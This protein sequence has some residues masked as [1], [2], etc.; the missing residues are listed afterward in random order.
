MN[1]IAK[2]G[3]KR[4]YDVIVQEFPEDCVVASQPGCL[5]AREARCA[6]IVILGRHFGAYRAL[7]FLEE[8]IKAGCR[9]EIKNKLVI[10]STYDEKEEAKAKELGVKIFYLPFSLKDL[11]DWL[12][13]CEGRS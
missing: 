12:A 11:D 9:L 13:E 10:C 8:Q 7:E 6:D 4:G 1:L 2:V 5:C 3:R